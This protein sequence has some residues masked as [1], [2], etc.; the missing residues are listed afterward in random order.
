MCRRQ[1]KT[2]E[3]GLLEA[4]Q[5]DRRRSTE[6]QRRPR[7]EEDEAD[8]VVWHA[9]VAAS[10]SREEDRQQLAVMRGV[11]KTGRDRGLLLFALLL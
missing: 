1:G 6:T 7:S 5:A 11:W 2:A 10:V 4:I 9:A 3:E 8:A